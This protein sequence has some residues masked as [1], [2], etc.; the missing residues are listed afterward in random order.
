MFKEHVFRLRYHKMTVL[1]SI[2]TTY[3]I[4]G[5]NKWQ[6]IKLLQ[7]SPYWTWCIADVYEGT[8]LRSSTSNPPCRFESHLG[9]SNSFKWE[10][11][12]VAL[13]KVSSSIQVPI[14]AWNTAR[15][16]GGGHPE[17]S[18]TH[19]STGVDLS[20]WCDFKIYV[21]ERRRCHRFVSTTI[22][23]EHNNRKNKIHRYLAISKLW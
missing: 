15:V 6:P 1:N 11:Y 8:W 2:A 12:P 10:I 21:C 7:E 14:R 13:R 18:S 3:L 19:N 9:A 4:P 5:V 23:V 22:T 16:W 20:C 17:F